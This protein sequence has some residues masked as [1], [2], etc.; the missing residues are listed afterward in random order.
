MES[1]VI[2]TTSNQN[3]IT[4]NFLEELEITFE[5]NSL[6]SKFMNLYDLNM[7]IQNVHLEMEFELTKINMKYLVSILNCFTHDNI[8]NHKIKMLK[9]LDFILYEF[10]RLRIKY[11]EMT[12]FYFSLDEENKYIRNI[13]NLLL[14]DELKPT[15]VG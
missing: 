6:I 8:E 14:T 5:Q 7:S 15:K 3:L 4:N 1:S 11:E 9:L 13:K 12:E 2:N 10:K